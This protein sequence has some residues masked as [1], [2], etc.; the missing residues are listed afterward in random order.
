M[1]APY[2]PKFV[3]N[4]AVILSVVIG[5]QASVPAIT[6]TTKHVTISDI[7]F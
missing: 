6:F 5:W 2:K 1:W 3:I 4:Q 7:V